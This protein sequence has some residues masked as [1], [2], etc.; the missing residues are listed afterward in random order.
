[1]YAYHKDR[2]LKERCSA[3]LKGLSSRCKSMK[4]GAIVTSDG[5]VVSTHGD[6]SDQ[7][8]RLGSM[9]SSM[10]ALAEAVHDELDLGEN[11][12]LAFAA[13]KG[14]IV[15]QKIGKYPLVMTVTFDDRET[16]GHAIFSMSATVD[17]VCGQ[18]KKTKS[19]A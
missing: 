1:M 10:Q 14:N 13:D 2:K 12:H 6:L 4:I 19:N 16:L 11:K 18:L 15:M 17:A 7:G 3:E 9:T 8:N 5:F